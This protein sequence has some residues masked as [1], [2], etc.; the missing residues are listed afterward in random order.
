MGN[1]FAGV[2]RPGQE[3]EYR[4][5]ADGRQYEDGDTPH[6]FPLIGGV[7]RGAAGDG[8][9]RLVARKL[10]DLAEADDLACGSRDRPRACLTDLL[11][12]AELEHGARS[13]LDPSFEDLLGN[14]EAEDERWVSHLARPETAAG[15]RQRLPRFRQ[16]QSADHPPAIVGMDRGS[17]RRIALGE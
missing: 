3:R 10:T 16:L 2:T 14:L 4:Q 7:L 15:R 6:P 17:G 8:G 5:A 1:A 9:D 11:L 13:R 12:D